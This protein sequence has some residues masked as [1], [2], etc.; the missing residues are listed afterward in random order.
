MTKHSG[1]TSP[2]DSKI[3]VAL[4]EGF[5]ALTRGQ[6]AQA[7]NICREILARHP[8]QVEAHF[9]VGLIALEL[10][11]R[12][13]AVN[14][15]G[16]VTRLAP[17]H[18]AAWAQLA[19]LFMQA[20]QPARAD[21][22]LVEAVAHETGNAA[23][24]DVIGTVFSLLGDQQAAFEWYHKAADWEPGHVGYRVNLANSL[25]FL[26]KTDDARQA[27]GAALKIQP[28]NP[29]AHWLLSGLQKATDQAH[30][31]V[32]ANCEEKLAKSPQ[33]IAFLGYAAGKEY[34]D[35][36]D[37]P[38]AF[39][40][41]SR[42]AAARRKLIEFSE[43]NEIEMFEALR[44]VFTED[45]LAADQESCDDPSPI[46]IV[47]QPRTGTTLVERIITSHSSVHSAGE[48][49]Q[50]GLSIKRLVDVESNQRFSAEQVR[51]SA[52]INP[53]Q[54]GRAYIQAS[55]KMRG[56]LPRFVDKLPTNFLH[57]PLIAKALPNARI[58]HLTRDPMDSC[59]S[60]FK[61]LF[62]EAYYH[63][64][65]QAEMAR[66]YIRYHR[67]MSHWR[68]LMPGRFLDVRYEDVARQLEP[69]ARRI[70]AHLGLPW[71]DACLDFHQQQAAVTTASAVQVRE[72]V[73]TRSIGR[74]LKY[75]VELAPMAEI[76]AAEGMLQGSESDG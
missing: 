25:I 70:I 53:G 10:K 18:S 42:G 64:Y 65:D 48:L 39:K 16:S 1:S 72:Q 69:N 5:T 21:K 41:F 66:H 57:L 12:R 7:G 28:W 34:E 73:H 58:I 9:L 56:T 31:E 62:A 13:T 22:A 61:Q 20:G 17:T 40:A 36:E 63:S 24:A 38:A 60:S 75:R 46:F 35:L 6:F 3:Q 54:L 55:T 47:G 8:E 14:A 67:I 32:M 49:Q 71:E 44:Q 37:W 11:D 15:F 45:W 68:Q 33:A 51:A 43:A 50:F 30:I 74:W 4:R 52:T 27:I 29:Q 59:F 19:R 2:I 23:V 76:L 26:G